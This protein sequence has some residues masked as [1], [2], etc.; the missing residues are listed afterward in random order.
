MD[1]AEAQRSNGMQLRYRNI[2]LELCKGMQP[3]ITMTAIA[4]PD[5]IMNNI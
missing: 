3:I 1:L 5:K 2:A 4:R